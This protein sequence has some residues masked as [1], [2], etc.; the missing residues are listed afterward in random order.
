MIEEDDDIT[1]VTKNYIIYDF[2]HQ[3]FMSDSQRSC[4]SSEHFS[5]T[6]KYFLKLK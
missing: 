2:M 6:N 3:Q 4:E 5:S 1:R